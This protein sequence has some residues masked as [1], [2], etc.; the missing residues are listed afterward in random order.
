[1]LAAGQ[2]GFTD[3]IVAGDRSNILSIAQA[4]AR[5]GV[6]VIWI[7]GG[8]KYPPID[9]RTPAQRKVDDE[10]AQ[11]E[12]RSRSRGGVHTATTDAKA[13]ER[14]YNEYMESRAS[15]GDLAQYPNL[16]LA[17]TGKNLIVVDAD[18]ASAVA[19]LQRLYANWTGG[20]DLPTPTETTPGVQTTDG[21]WTHKNGGHWFFWVESGLPEGTRD[22]SIGTGDEQVSVLAGAK[23]VVTAPSMR[24]EG[25]YELV[26]GVYDA[27]PTLVDLVTERASKRAF[28]D[29]A[30][31]SG[32]SE[33]KVVEAEVVEDNP[34]D[35][36][37]R[38]F[39]WDYVLPQYGWSPTGQ[40]DSCGCPIF[41]APG[42]HASPKSATAHQC[43]CSEYDTSAGHGPVHIW[44]DNPPPQLAEWIDK[45]GSR[46]LSMVQF[47]AAMEAGGD[48]RTLLHSVNV[49]LPDNADWAAAPGQK[50][51]GGLVPAATSSAP[52]PATTDDLVVAEDDTTPDQDEVYRRVVAEVEAELGRTLNETE[53]RRLHKAVAKG[54]NPY[55]RMF[56]LG[57]HSELSLVR[58]IVNFSP[59]T[60]AIF[61]AS[62][63]GDRTGQPVTAVVAELLRIGRRAPV[64]LRTPTGE[65]LSSY[66]VAVGKSGSGKTTTLTKYTPWPIIDPF[67][68]THGLV[69]HDELD[70]TRAPGSGEALVD[71]FLDSFETEDPETGK[72]K[73]EKVM[74]DDPSIMLFTD[75]VA[76][77]VSAA[78]RDGSTIASMLTSAWSE[79][80]IGSNTRSHGETRV[81]GKYSL[82]LKGGLQPKKASAY[83]ALADIGIVQ[84]T[85]TLP[86]AWVWSRID[87]G[88]PD[89]GD[90]PPPSLTIAENT[91]MSACNALYEAVEDAEIL[92]AIDTAD[93]EDDVDSHLLAVRIRLASLATLLHSTLHVDEKLWEWSGWVIDVH[94][95][96]RAWL[97]AACV[98]AEAEEAHRQGRLY[99]H[100]KTGEA[101]ETGDLMSQTASRVL[102]LITRAG[103]A[104]ATQ[105]KIKNNL[106]ASKKIYLQP[107]LDQLLRNGQIT[108]D[109][110]RYKAA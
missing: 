85:I 105:G 47:A 8:A 48:V 17:L 71:F 52:V 45:T 107:A 99:A 37:A 79:A 29:N 41:T 34:I 57:Y 67:W 19:H 23:Y 43:G 10:A 66:M 63:R 81:E 9:M 6:P 27:P 51:A 102:G 110:S 13:I 72:K 31:D 30:S 36:W 25:S 42:N 3:D 54:H 73:T 97:Q 16:G 84:R 39:T 74:K 86:A 69:T 93:D 4:W 80:P 60:R 5:R 106:V 68:D 78:G 77:L 55:S 18:T 12:G 62:Q 70:R 32:L 90:V 101:A 83:L 1:M 49:P 61:H 82:F 28:K 2:F 14:A 53:S 87:L 108:Q 95:R 58:R 65:P 89:P 40:T 15:A 109:G 56:P 64:S 20:D 75:E 22:L 21:Q 44:T 46:T 26:G 11:A 24:A 94:R 59:Q 38:Q 7:E 35:Q 50:L 33:A 100:R 88:I 103:D 91:R 96:T 76:G 92:S 98:E 104:G